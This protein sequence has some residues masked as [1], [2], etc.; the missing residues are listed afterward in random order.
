M[1]QDRTKKK[2][3]DT[4]QAILD[5]AGELFAI[6]GLDGT[7]IR[8]I[9][10]AAGTAL[11]SV[12]YH[13]ENK[14]QLYVE[15]V[16]YVIEDKL[17]LETALEVLDDP[18]PLSQEA[19][20]ALL[21]EMIRRMF[22]L[23]LNPD[24]PYWYGILLIRAKQEFNPRVKPVITSITDPERIKNFLVRHIPDLD[25]DEAYLWV[26]NLVAQIQYYV[27][28]KWTVL[29]TL[30]KKEYDQDWMDMIASYTVDNLLKTLH[31]S[32]RHQEWGAVCK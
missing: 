32:D 28:S 27:V 2:R 12:N 1:E 21:S 19:F 24:N 5:A 15:C 22:F 17:A 11:C 26:F 18:S 29:K 9:V 3:I 13:F 20:T 31:L 6:R 23:F 25:P 10:K 7:S 30:G 16:R 8:E 4:R 14:E